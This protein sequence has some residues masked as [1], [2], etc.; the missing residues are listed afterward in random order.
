MGRVS[1][2][3][4]CWSRGVRLGSAIPPFEGSYKD[5]QSGSP[6]ELRESFETGAARTLS[7]H[8]EQSL[9]AW[10]SL[11]PWRLDRNGNLAQLALVGGWK[12]DFVKLSVTG[13]RARWSASECFP[14]SLAPVVFP[15]H[16][17]FRPMT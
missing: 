3:P 12:R 2:L 14:E 6:A 4:R 8:V 1:V 10:T 9:R 15:A 11:N 5:G 17:N 16:G 13:F 7:T